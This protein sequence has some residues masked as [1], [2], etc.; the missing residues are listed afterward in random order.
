MTK[1][2]RIRE[3]RN[4]VGAYSSELG[5]LAN[6]DNYLSSFD[7]EFANLVAFIGCRLQSLSSKMM[8]VIHEPEVGNE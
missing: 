3:L 5:E 2:E 4:I 6:R 7:G 1:A 8:D